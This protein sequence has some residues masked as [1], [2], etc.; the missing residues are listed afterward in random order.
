M[1]NDDRAAR[2]LRRFV[3]VNEI[4]EW[5]II[6]HSQKWGDGRFHL[7]KRDREVS[8]YPLQGR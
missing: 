3:C 1:E 2:D 6:L 7:V 8:T 5:K 4:A